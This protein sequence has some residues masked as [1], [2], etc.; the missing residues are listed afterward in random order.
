[1]QAI[2]NLINIKQ[3]G[4]HK[5]TCQLH[6]SYKPQSGQLCKTFKHHDKVYQRVDSVDSLVG[7]SLIPDDIILITKSEYNEDIS[8]YYVEFMHSGKLYYC[9]FY[10]QVFFFDQDDTGDVHKKDK[11]VTSFDFPWVLCD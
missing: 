3:K 8:A 10:E 2:T 5:M 1:M 4:E 7:C 6:E 9:Y 11:P